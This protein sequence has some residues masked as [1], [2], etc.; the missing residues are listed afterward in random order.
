M[1]KIAYNKI[2]TY[3]LNKE[4]NYKSLEE[5]IKQYKNSKVLETVYIINSTKKCS[6]LMEEIKKIVDDDDQ[7]FVAELLDY[8]VYN[9]DSFPY[10]NIIK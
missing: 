1:S 5:Y 7:V 6:E 10:G 8:N 3:D 9:I 2:I 4:K